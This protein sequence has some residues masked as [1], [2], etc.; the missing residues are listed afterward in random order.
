MRVCLVNDDGTDG[1]ELYACNFEYGYRLSV[2]NA[3]SLAAHSDR[4]GE[5]RWIRRGNIYGTINAVDA[6]GGDNVVIL[7]GFGLNGNE[8]RAGYAVQPFGAVTKAAGPV[9]FA[10]DIRPPERFADSS[11]CYAYVEVGGDAYAQGVCRPKSN[12]GWRIEP[13]IGFGFYVGAGK[14]DVGLYTNVLISVQTN[15]STS[16]T[17]S[18]TNSNYVIDKSHWYRFRVTADQDAKKFTVKVYDQGTA[19]PLASDADG[20]LVATFEDLVLPDFGENGM[21]TFGLAGAGFAST[22]GKLDDPGVV[23]VDNLAAFA[24]NALT[25]FAAFLDEYDIPTDTDPM[26]VTNGIPLAARYVYGIEPM[27]ATTNAEGHLLVDFQLGANG[28]PVFEL[29]PQKR[30]DDFGLV[31]SILWSSTLSPWETRGE[32]RFDADNDGDDLL[33]H[34]PVDPGDEPCMFFKFKIESPI[35]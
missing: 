21:T 2:Q 32:M 35:P 31:F 18:S 9:E 13:R 3:A 8:T 23:L 29:A 34:P 6:G 24:S 33:C 22:F 30:T 15:T 28:A 7:D 17:A 11:G 16:A 20:T 5:D 27:D 14:D 26:T 19:K 4:E 10:A 1:T 25:G 12:S